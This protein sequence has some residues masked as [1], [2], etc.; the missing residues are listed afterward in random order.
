MDPESFA[1]DREDRAPTEHKR[2]R[3]RRRL[4]QGVH[5]N[6]LRSFALA[7]FITLGNA[8][9]GTIAIFLCL[10]HL[11]EGARQTL[12]I[13]LGLLPIALM[14]DVADGTIARWRHKKS[15][16]GGDL[17]SL[18]DVISFGVAPAV[19]GYTLGLRGLIDIAILVFF[20]SCG[21]GRLARYNV[22]SEALS[23]GTGKVKY[24]EG[25]PIPGSLGIVGMLAFLFW[26]E[27][28]GPALP[29]GDFKVLGATFHPIA[30]AYLATGAAMV[31]ETLR[32]PK[33]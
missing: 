25:L 12:W 14:L 26:K 7:D 23:E 2:K 15:P 18:A 24:Y 20:V 31:S 5:F 4:I 13:A 16:F 29:G 32:I 10:N 28:V 27:W 19:L 6:L 33:P 3:K 11:A 9:C 1:E 21:I 30:I 22:T 17:D 8:A